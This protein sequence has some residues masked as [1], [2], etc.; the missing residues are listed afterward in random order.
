M[1]LSVCLATYQEA[2][3]IHFAL[4]SVIDFADEVVVVD[5]GSTDGTVA[6]LQS[7]GPKVR[8]I[9]TTNKPM[10][11]I[12]KQMALDAARGEWILQLDADEEITTDMRDEILHIIDEGGASP[13]A[14][15][16]PRRNFFLGRPLMKGGVYPDYTI[17]LYKKG[18]MYFPCKDVH[19]NVV[20]KTEQR[21]KY[22]EQRQE[23]KEQSTQSKVPRLRSG[24]VPAGEQ[25]AKYIEQ[26]ENGREKGALRLRSGQVPFKA[27]SAWLGTLK[28]PMNHYSDP[29]FQRYLTRWKRYNAAE[30]KRVIEH[31]EHLHNDDHVR[32]VLW[33]IVF[34]MKAFAVLPLVWF[35]RTYIRHKG[36]MDGWQGLVFHGMSALRWWGIGWNVL[37]A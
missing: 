15:Q 11:H 30:A 35:F 33:S 10:F 7:Y 16:I 19:E 8:I 20:P 18:T 4:D 13:I 6:I 2:K 29:D 5:G 3:N 37:R 34:I 26:S 23:S 21:A 1:K 31:A 9:T 25:R 17:R 27:Q 32:F 36:F 22:I 14:Y 12:N 28:H 24:Q